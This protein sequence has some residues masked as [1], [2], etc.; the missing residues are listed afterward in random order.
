MAEALKEIGI[1][2][3]IVLISP[4][5]SILLYKKNDGAYAPLEISKQKR[6]ILDNLRKDLE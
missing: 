6:E 2:K 5:Q 4:Y 3:E 1:N